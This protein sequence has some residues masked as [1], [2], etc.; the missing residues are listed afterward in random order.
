MLIIAPHAWLPITCATLEALSPLKQNKLD[1]NLGA[2]VI[3]RS[4]LLHISWPVPWTISP[5]MQRHAVCQLLAVQL[6]SFRLQ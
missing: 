5:H 4:R 2:L 1:G 3:P 6:L